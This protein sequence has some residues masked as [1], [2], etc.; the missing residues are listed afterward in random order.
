MPGRLARRP[1]G[2]AQVCPGRR[3]ASARLCRG[4]RSPRLTRSGAV[5]GSGWMSERTWSGVGQAGDSA[6]GPAT[7]RSGRPHCLNGELARM[8]VS[9]LEDHGLHPRLVTYPG[10]PGDEERVEQIVIVNSA[11]PERGE[12]RI[13]DDGSV[14]WEYFGSLDEAGVSM[15]LDEV[16]SALRATG[17]RLAGDCQS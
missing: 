12:V 6:S 10:D 16:T 3:A 5:A 7:A 2:P 14:T 11:A 8:L 13:G 9:S 4:W 1:P 15:I 17:V